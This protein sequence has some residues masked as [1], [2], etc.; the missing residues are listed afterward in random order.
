ML[1]TSEKKEIKDIY[2]FIEQENKALRP[3]GAES[4]PPPVAENIQF[5][6]S[7]KVGD[8]IH[9]R[10]EVCEVVREACPLL[11]NGDERSII[12]VK[13]KRPH[14]KVPYNLKVSKDFEDSVEFMFSLHQKY[15]YLKFKDL[16]VEK[17]DLRT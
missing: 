11:K 3:K 5:I 14:L 13:V 9:L 6:R 1:T 2:K 12:A 4:P 8:K 10:D 15:I 17:A 16:K 7:L